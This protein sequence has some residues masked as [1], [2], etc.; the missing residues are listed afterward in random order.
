MY[1]FP[2]QKLSR[3]GWQGGEMGE[4]VASTSDFSV[5]DASFTLVS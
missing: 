1:W 5:E 2:S 4:D 3:G